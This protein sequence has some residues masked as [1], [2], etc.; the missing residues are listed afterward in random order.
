MRSRDSGSD[1][2]A[3]AGIR[4]DLEVFHASA[5]AGRTCDGSGYVAKLTDAMWDDAGGHGRLLIM[6]DNHS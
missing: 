6:S 3:G 4:A 5:L 2:G 1:S